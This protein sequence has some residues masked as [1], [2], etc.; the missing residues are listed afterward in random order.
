MYNVSKMN[1]LLLS[2][3]IVSFFGIISLNGATTA[4]GA[5]MTELQAQITALLAQVQALQAQLAEVSATSVSG[6]IPDEL[7]SSGNLTLGSSG[8]V[9]TVLQNYLGMNTV[10][11]YFGNLTKTALAKW[12]A[13]NGVSPAA[14]YF[15]A[16]TR[17]KL[18]SVLGGAVVSTP[19]APSIPA[20][21]ATTTIAE[22][23]IIATSTSVLIPVLPNPFDSTLK[24]EGIF[25]S[26]VY[27]TYGNKI[28]NEIKFTADEKIGITRIKFKNTG[29]FLDNY[30]V[31]LQLINSRTDKVVATV[32]TPKDKV[33]DF[34]M[35]FDVTKPDNGLAISGETYYIYA[36]ILT[37]NIGQLKPKI[38]LDIES[39]S[40][41]SAFD[42]NDLTRVADVTK[43]NTF[44]I[45]G[46]VITIW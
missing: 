37:P 18:A 16:V 30:L 2:A 22:P 36:Y 34:K 24:I 31:S 29:T 20:V 23:V 42:Y 43:N 38:Q 14:G 12:Q 28:L 13:A 15:G 44:P 11:G 7:L 5:T 6:S 39:V 1:K 3:I 45:A 46:P 25:Q 10:T 35:T 21:V 41:I 19:A 27:S 8:A 9:V 26:R 17:A 33:I 32:D 4:Y 40:D